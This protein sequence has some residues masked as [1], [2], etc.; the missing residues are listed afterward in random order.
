L[1]APTKEEFALPVTFVPSALTDADASPLIAALNAH[2]SAAYPNPAD[3]HWTFS[4][5]EGLFV[6]AYVDGVPAGCGGL[7]DFGDGRAELKRMYVDPAFRGRGLGFA[8]VEH[9]TQHARTLG[10]SRLLLETGA[11]LEA[12]VRLYERCGFREVERY[13]EYLDSPQSLC[14]GKDL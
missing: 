13:G 8:L 14:M 5:E 7:R 10:A 1:W 3:N 2:A 12:A 11:R 4:H 6:V 9:L